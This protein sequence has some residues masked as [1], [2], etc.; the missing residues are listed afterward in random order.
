MGVRRI[1]DV[2]TG[3]DATIDVDIEVVV[4]GDVDLDEDA[5]PRA[6]LGCLHHIGDPAFVDGR[7]A[8][9]ATRVV[10]GFARLDDIRDAIFEEREHVGAMVDAQAVA[11]AQ[12]LVDPYSHARANLSTTRQLGVE[13]RLA[14][15]YTAAMPDAPL[16]PRIPHVWHRATGDVVDHYAWL[17]DA[18]DPDVIA[19]LE[20]END[21]HE[22]WFAPH[23]SLVDAI[24][25]EIR[26]RTAE[27]DTSAPTQR[28]PWWYVTATEEGHPYPRIHRGRSADTA[29]DVVI[30]DLNIEAAGS[31]Y[32]DLGAFDVSPD[33]SMAAWSADTTGD[34]HYTLRIR[35]LSNGADIDDV[36]VDTTSAGTAW[37]TDGQQLFY[38]TADDQERPFRVMRHRL[39]TGQ[40]DD[41][42]IYRDNDQR[43]FVSIG[44]SRNERSIIIHSGS[45]TSAEAWLLD[46]S[47]PFAPARLVRARSDDVEYQVDDW[48][49]DLVVLTNLD[50]TDFRVMTAPRAQP[51][52]WSE[53]VPHQAGRRIIAIDPFDGFLAIQEWE[54]AQEQ[55]RIWR[56]DSSTWVLD[57]DPEPHSL[58]VGENYEWTTDRLRLHHQSLT[59]PPRT[60]DVAINSSTI[61]IVKQR[62][63]PNTNLDDYVST[64]VWATADDG[65]RVPVDV[66]HHVDTAMDGT[67]PCTIYGYGS[68]EASMPPWFSVA[69]LS[70]LDR[71]HVWALAHPRGG[72]E[73]GRQW[74]LEGRLLHKRNTFI[75]TLAAA[76]ELRGAGFAGPLGLR[77][78]SAGGLLV[79]ACVTSAPSLFTAA[80]AE[81]PFVDVVT[82]MSNPEL[83]LTVT[84]WEEWGDPRSE[85]YA[86]YI[87][88]YSPYD[89]TV[90][91]DYPAML[92]TG[93]LNDPRVGFQEP[94]K[95]V[96]RLRYVG[97]GTSPVLLRTELGAGHGGRSDRYE[98]WR[99][100]AQVLTFLDIALSSSSPTGDNRATW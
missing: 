15:A 5:L 77:G 18:S 46:P 99:D 81:V 19:Y 43:F 34:E 66:V 75:D 70:L 82:T 26:S 86:S 28:G 95:W 96:A 79:G 50:A 61:T 59:A 42:E 83:P 54:D 51:S 76:R 3:R 71:G 38:V 48:G 10:L 63:T 6:D 84:E 25:H 39:G 2:D 69:R 74:Y 11:G 57:I 24:F 21:Y 47:N 60:I 45:K 56:R 91:M 78:A 12:V 64:R 41:V 20:A 16:A 94:A 98:A 97:T 53:L 90:P 4:D 7:Q 33:Q 40:G 35:D 9:R 87:E 30:L 88:S 37:S 8:P 65:A 29:T 14:R 31:D 89:N 49:D 62:P 100:E 55:I 17:A 92:I 32:F 23:A 93:G 44:L 80:V 68:Y 85:P 22:R 27:T 36:I 67:A 58:G 72:G 13:R 1:G 52:S 73:L